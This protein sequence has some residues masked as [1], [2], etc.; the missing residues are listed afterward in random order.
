MPK[1]V[2]LKVSVTLTIKE[3]IRRRGRGRRR[4]WRRVIII[5]LLRA[6]IAWTI[7]W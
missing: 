2:T 5:A 1:L 7:R 3:R 6:A 4:E